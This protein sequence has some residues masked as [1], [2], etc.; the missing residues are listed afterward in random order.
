[1]LR[2][3]LLIAAAIVIVWVA[4]LVIHAILWALIIGLIILA[5]GLLLGV[6][7]VGQSARRR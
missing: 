5:A 7:R 4:T 3:L 2:I 1:M 6:F